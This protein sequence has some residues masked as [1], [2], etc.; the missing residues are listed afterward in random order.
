MFN[1][2]GQREARRG[3]GSVD[4]R[5]PRRQRDRRRLDCCDACTISSGRHGVAEDEHRTA[6]AAVVDGVVEPYRPRRSSHP[7]RRRAADCYI[8]A[9]DQGEIDR[10]AGAIGTGVEEVS[11]GRGEI[12][13][14]HFGCAQFGGHTE[15]SCGVADGR[16]PCA[17]C[18][19]VRHAHCD[20]TVCGRRYID[21]PDFGGGQRLEVG[22][23]GIGCVEIGERER[24][25]EAGFGADLDRGG[26]GNDQVVG[27]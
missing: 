2:R 23:R 6:A 7:H 12:S 14:D 20:R 18:D 9:E 11:A 26:A 15:R 19:S 27:A 22:E 24:R 17:P 21:G 1:Q 4:D 10:V 13:P 8:F 16:I 25:R 3:S 5:C